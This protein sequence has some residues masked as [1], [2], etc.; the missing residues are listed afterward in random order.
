MQIEESGINR[1]QAFF[2][3][4]FFTQVFCVKKGTMT[5][6]MGSCILSDFI[7]LNI[8]AEA[9]YH[10]SISIQNCKGDYLRKSSGVLVCLLDPT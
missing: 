5:N 1:S 3:K 8:R 7:G 10:R 4:A 6:I 2:T 9:T